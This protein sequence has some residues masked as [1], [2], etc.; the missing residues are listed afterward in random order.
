M[1]MMMTEEVSTRLSH[2]EYSKPFATWLYI[3]DDNDIM[4]LCLATTQKVICDDDYDADDD[5]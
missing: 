2:Y 5:A 4:M 3:C 1:M